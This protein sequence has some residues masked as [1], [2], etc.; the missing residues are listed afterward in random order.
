MIINAEREVDDDMGHQLVRFH[1]GLSVLS[2]SK[3]FLVNFPCF[4]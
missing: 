1:R 4:S 3:L 2:H